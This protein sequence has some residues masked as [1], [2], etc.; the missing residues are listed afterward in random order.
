MSRWGHEHTSAGPHAPR[1]LNAV[2]AAYMCTPERQRPPARAWSPARIKVWLLRGATRR[3]LQRAPGSRRASL[4]SQGLRSSDGCALP[5]FQVPTRQRSGV[6][7]CC[8]ETRI[9]CT[10]TCGPTQRMRHPV[11][12]GSHGNGH[13]LSVHCAVTSKSSRSR[14]PQAIHGSIVEQRDTGAAG[15]QPQVAAGW[16]LAVWRRTLPTSSFLADCAARE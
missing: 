2:V 1:S 15:R 8:A 7:A 11:R 3:I 13:G 14:R 9:S 6:P 16:E 4:R 5:T 12:C 10:T